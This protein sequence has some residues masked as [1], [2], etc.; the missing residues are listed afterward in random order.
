[1]CVCVWY[2]CV[3]GECMLCVCVCV[4]LS[5]PNLIYITSECSPS[6]CDLMVLCGC[7]GEEV[8]GVQHAA[9]E[10]SG[11]C[12]DPGCYGLCYMVAM[13]YVIYMY[14]YLWLGGGGGGILGKFEGPPQVKQNPSPKYLIPNGYIPAMCLYASYVLRYHHC[15][16]D[17]HCHRDCSSGV[18]FIKEQRTYCQGSCAQ[19]TMCGPVLIP[20]SH[21]QVSRPCTP[22]YY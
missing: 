14:G 18:Q 9:R 22:P 20:D 3:C 5:F 15:H 8:G 11:V 12:G 16:G 17:H 4:C 10:V 19:A 1:M 2:V 13:E 21:L 6:G 7:E